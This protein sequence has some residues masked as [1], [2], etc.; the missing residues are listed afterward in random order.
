MTRATRYITA[1]MF[2]IV[3]GEVEVFINRAFLLGVKFNFLSPV[4]AVF[5]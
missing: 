4:V 1:V 3:S 2:Y 5:S